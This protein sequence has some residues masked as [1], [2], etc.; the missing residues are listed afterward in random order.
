VVAENDVG[1]LKTFHV[2]GFQGE[3]L[4][5]EHDLGQ[6]PNQPGP[7]PTLPLGVLGG[8]VPLFISVIYFHNDLPLSATHSTGKTANMQEPLCNCEHKI[9]KSAF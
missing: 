4:S 6:E 5:P 9:E 1:G 2:D 8:F 3:F 7:K